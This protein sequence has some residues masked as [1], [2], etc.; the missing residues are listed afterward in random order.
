MTAEHKL[1]AAV[2]PDDVKS[3]MAA[4][5]KKAQGGDVAAAKFCMDRADHDARIAAYDEDDLAELL[6]GKKKIDVA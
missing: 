6:G 2:T 1:A 3:I 4:V 5:I